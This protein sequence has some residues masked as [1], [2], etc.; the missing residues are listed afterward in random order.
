MGSIIFRE[1]RIPRCK[2]SLCTQ[3]VYGVLDFL[4]LNR[5][6]WNYHWSNFHVYCLDDHPQ[7]YLK[8][9]HFI[10]ITLCHQT[11]SHVMNVNYPCPQAPQSFQ[12]TWEKWKMLKPEWGLRTAL[13]VNYNWPPAACYLLQVCETS[14]RTQII[15]TLIW[16][17][18]KLTIT[19]SGFHP[20][21]FTRGSKL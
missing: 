20:D 1:I 6:G 9:H 5:R 13:V 21:I 19:I 8:F 16:Y 4:C 11:H 18:H 15:I 10:D 7:L 17:Y 12:H 14:K 2:N 3:W